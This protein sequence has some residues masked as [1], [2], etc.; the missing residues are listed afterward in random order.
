[1]ALTI[2]TAINENDLKGP[3][4]VS[5]SM[6]CRGVCP[7]GVSVPG[8]LLCGGCVCSRGCLLP[9]GLGGGSP[10]CTEADP[11]CE[12]NHTCLWKHNLASTSLRTVINLANTSRFKFLK[13]SICQLCLCILTASNVLVQLVYGY[14]SS[15]VEGMVALRRYCKILLLP[16]ILEWVLQVGH[17]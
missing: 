6:L 13:N 17:G 3:F 16:T 8:G 11:P 4:I 10:A 15:S 1:M 9:E 2:F 12:Q 14:D 5:P 7:G